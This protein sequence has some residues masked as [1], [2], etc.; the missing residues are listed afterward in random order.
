MFC[1]F[2]SSGLEFQPEIQHTYLVVIYI[3]TGVKSI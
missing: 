1:S 3:H 2:L